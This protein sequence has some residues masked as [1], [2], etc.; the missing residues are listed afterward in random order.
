MHTIK[1]LSHIMTEHKNIQLILSRYEDYFYY[2]L[3]KS[4]MIYLMYFR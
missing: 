4:K 1:V 3:Y 2:S